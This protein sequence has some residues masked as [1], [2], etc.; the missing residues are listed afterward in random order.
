MYAELQPPRILETLTVLE[1]RIEERFPGSGLSRIGTELR[2]RAEVAEVELTRLRRPIWALRI[3]A[4][5]GILTTLAVAISLLVVGLRVLIRVEDPTTLLTTTESAA[6]EVI[7]LVLA[8]AFLVSLETRV[9]RRAALRSL[10]RLRSIVHIVDMHQLT[11][12]P[13]AL[14]TPERATASS[15]KRTYT[16]FELAR[17]L[18]YCSE[19]LS[20]TGKLAALH[21][22]Y[23]N[24]PVVLNAVNDVEVLGASLSNK[25][26]Q[27]IMI[28]DVAAPAD[29]RAHASEETANVDLPSP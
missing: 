14:L 7:L 1:R 16:R 26:W 10:H 19:L 23:L 24:D 13:K 2:Q 28:L 12:D 4:A 27:K 9:K 5:L 25:V 8:I 20:M 29:G 6:N 18:D 22:Q 11:K 21:V 3:T 15:P 17:Y